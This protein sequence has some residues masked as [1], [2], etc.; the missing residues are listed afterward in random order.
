M[1]GLVEVVADGVEFFFQEEH[2]CEVVVDAL[3]P[4]TD[5]DGLAEDGFAN[6]FGEFAA[7]GLPE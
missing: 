7:G 1:D 6:V 3:V 4:V 2:V 5:V